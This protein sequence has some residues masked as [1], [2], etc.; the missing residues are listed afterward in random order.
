M[1]DYVGRWKC[2]DCGTEVWGILRHCPN[3]GANT[4]GK[5]YLPEGEPPTTEEEV[6]RIIQAGP[7]WQCRF[8]QSDNYGDT[9]FCT[10]CGGSRD[11]TKRRRTREY[12]AEEVP[13]TDEDVSHDGEPA[14]EPARTYGHSSFASTRFDSSSN[15]W[16]GSPRV[17]V[18]RFMKPA[19]IALVL[20]VIAGLVYL[21]LRPYEVH[22]AIDRFEWTRTIHID[23]Y[24]T[25]REGDWSIPAGGRYVSDEQRIHH[26]NRVLDHYETKT[27]QV[28]AGSEQFVCGKTDNGNGTFSDRY[29]TRTIYRTE[30][31]QDPV[32][33]NDPVYQ[34]WYHYDIDKWVPSRVVPTGNSNRNDPLPYWGN[35]NL[36]CAN[37]AILGC[38]RESYRQEHYYV[39]FRWQDGDQRKEFRHEE[40]RADWDSYDAQGE[41]TLVLNGLNVLLNDPLRPEKK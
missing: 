10:E 35:F 27:R 20:L 18:S 3:C 6:R 41:F 26:Y 1:A 9:G 16:E 12:G 32:Y 11:G 23:Q 5:Y 21:L 17:D 7:N 4:T 34:T 33:R 31:Y 36:E 8:C 37:Q 24:R 2:D 25:V 29:C 15:R 22:T 28:S 39:V 14:G 13:H 30:T 38:E 19:L 40:E